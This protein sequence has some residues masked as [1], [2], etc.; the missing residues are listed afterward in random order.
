MDIYRAAYP[1]RDMPEALEFETL[2]KEM[3]ARL[4]LPDAELAQLTQM[5]VEDV[6][7]VWVNKGGGRR[8][9]NEADEAW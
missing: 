3:K 2:W 1:V 7:R 6:V 8:T 4:A 5:T 9:R